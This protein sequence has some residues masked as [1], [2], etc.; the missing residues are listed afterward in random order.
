[1]SADGTGLS[2]RQY[3]QEEMK[4]YL[5]EIRENGTIEQEIKHVQGI[6]QMLHRPA[7]MKMWP[8]ETKESI[9]TKV[10]KYNQIFKHLLALKESLGQR[11]PS[12]QIVVPD[13]IEY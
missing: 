7:Y 2:A 1:M 8:N 12:L 5:Q 10:C 11:K 4:T 9:Q 6:L 3:T 13:Q